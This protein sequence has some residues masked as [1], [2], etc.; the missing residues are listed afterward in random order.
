VLRHER[1]GHDPEEAR[2]RTF[3]SDEQNALLVDGNLN[4]PDLLIEHVFDG[5]SLSS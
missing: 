5:S 3:G 4:R 1:H 2:I